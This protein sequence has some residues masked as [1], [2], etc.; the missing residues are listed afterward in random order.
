MC[1]IYSLLN[2][3]LISNKI[4]RK[5]PKYQ[6]TLVHG[7]IIFGNLNLNYFKGISSICSNQV[8]S[9]FKLFQWLPWSLSSSKWSKKSSHTLAL[10]STLICLLP[11]CRFFS[12]FQGRS[13][14][15]SL[16][17]PST[18]PHLPLE[19]YVMLFSMFGTPW[20][21]WHGGFPHFLQV[22]ALLSL[23]KIIPPVLQLL[24]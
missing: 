22:S 9:Q 16:N 23:Y 15:C 8:T 4:S 13:P 3:L 1:D 12:L 14:C 20:E 6:I 17:T 21:Y 7:E 2:S 11:F 19:A 10:P 5:P 18:L 24:K